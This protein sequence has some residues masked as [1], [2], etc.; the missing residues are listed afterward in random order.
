MYDPNLNQ[1]I[2]IYDTPLRKQI[3][4]DPGTKINRLRDP[5][6]E[7]VK[8]GGPG[9]ELMNQLLWMVLSPFGQSSSST[10]YFKK[11]ANTVLFFVYFRSFQT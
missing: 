11:W 4:V 6:G 1:E 10:S 2:L 7:T 9:S 3:F 8:T 5:S